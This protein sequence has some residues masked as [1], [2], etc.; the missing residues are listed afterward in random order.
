MFGSGLKAVA[1]S[2][3][4]PAASPDD[5]AVA[6]R[7]ADQVK[8][9]C[10]TRD[11]DLLAE[12]LA[13]ATRGLRLRAPKLPP[14]EA[15]ALVLES[16]VRAD[17]I[18][19]ANRDFVSR[20][21][22]R[23]SWRRWA[24]MLLVV[25]FVSALV[26]PA[27]AEEDPLREW[28][29]GGLGV[30]ASILAVY[31][32]IAVAVT[33]DSA[34]LLRQIRA[35]LP[36]RPKISLE[37][38]PEFPW[39]RDEKGRILPDS[40]QTPVEYGAYRMGEANCSTTCLGFGDKSKLG[41]QA[42]VLTA[43]VTTHCLSPDRIGATLMGWTTSLA[44]VLRKC[45]CNAHN[46]LCHRHGTQQ[47]V[48][49]R[50]IMEVFSDFKDAV[51]GDDA[52]YHFDPY[53]VYEWW[54]QKW[55]ENRRRSFEKS[56]ATDDVRPN[57]VKAMVK[58]EVN[59]KRPTKARL[60][61]FYP[62]LATQAEFGPEF[63]ALQKTLCRRFRRHRMGSVDVTI[64]S[65][66]NPMEIADWMR[67]VQQEGAVCF[68]ER[69][70]KNW[71]ASM[72]AQHADFRQNLYELFDERLAHFAR[73]C[74]AVTGMAAFEGGVFRYRVNGTV[75]S[76]HNDTTLGNS[77]VNAAI[78]V[79][80]FRRIGVP[81][82]ILVA[83]DDLLVAC[84]GHVECSVVAA[85]E[86]EYGITP[87]ARVF[88][89]FEHVSF[90]SGIF[91]HDG[92]DYHFVPTPGRLLA[93]LWWTINPPPQKKAGP[94]LRGV[95][96]G[97]L[98]VLSGMPVLGRFVARYDDGGSAVLSNKCRLFRGVSSPLL[99]DVYFSFASRYGVSVEDLVE[100]EA[101]LDSL[102][103]GALFLRHPVLDAIMEVDLADVAERGNQ[104]WPPSLWQSPDTTALEARLPRHE[105]QPKR[106]YPAPQPS[107]W[108]NVLRRR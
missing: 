7:M 78:A 3:R 52:A 62:N 59:H 34:W 58:R 90:I 81:A 99:S 80:A 107:S 95:A 75:K 60:I 91:M 22:R 18:D 17:K 54:L 43:N 105:P 74:N 9:T 10:K 93:R 11:V 13:T 63:Y 92:V 19:H 30:G 49:S 33:Q 44:W 70:G 36:S 100:T 94:Y 21:A 37:S 31:N 65:G 79:A 89:D 61:Q 64:A 8:N 38:L 97:L 25:L 56:R 35:N 67:Q 104:V 87:E 66:M 46:A 85:Y 27:Y 72:Q 2:F 98:G 23:A 96:R 71:D 20:Y 73:A 68:Y 51:V 69:D 1:P 50:S 26:V 32:R 6:Q 82:S 45:M 77:L 5:I 86:A 39:A 24:L 53:R 57:R 101:W 48:A 12:G 40:S 76:G 102:P 103:L 84:Y 106:D 88:N 41:A 83:G 14:D 16:W 29:V 4:R 42:S 47:P 108:H 55:P 28:A 15:N